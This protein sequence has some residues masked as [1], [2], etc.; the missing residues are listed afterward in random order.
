[1]DSFAFRRPDLMNRIDVFK[2]DHPVTQRRKLER[3]R[4][5]RLT[6]PARLHYVSADLTEISALDAL[7]GSGFDMS[8]PNIP[9][10]AGGCLLSHSRFSGRDVR[11]TSRHLP[12]GTLLVIDYL[13]DEK[14]AKPKH[15]LMR[16]KMRSF[17][18]RLREPMV[19]E[20]SLA[21]M[22]TLMSAQ[23]FE[24]SRPQFA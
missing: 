2:I 20:Y 1:M 13:L 3:M 14:S 5:A 22:N 16:K 4:R 15:L 17:V 8:R 10:P 7:A 18:A 6:I 11:S 12:A 21:A 9:D 19:S 23:G 24:R